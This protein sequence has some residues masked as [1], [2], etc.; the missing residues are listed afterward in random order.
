MDWR[1]EEERKQVCRTQF[2]HALDHIPFV[3]LSMPREKIQHLGFFFFFLFIALF[4]VLVPID[5]Y[6]PWD[7]SFYF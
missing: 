6:M 1:D 7:G 3:H 2:P 5:L 4:I